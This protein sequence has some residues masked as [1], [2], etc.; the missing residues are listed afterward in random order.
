MWIS[1][2]SRKNGLIWNNWVFTVKM[3]LH[4]S[5]NYS[6]LFERVN[7][8]M[9]FYKYSLLLAS[10]RTS[11]VQ[12]LVFVAWCNCNE[13]ILGYNGYWSKCDTLQSCSLSV[14][15]WLRQ[16]T[17]IF[18]WTSVNDSKFLTF[19][20]YWGLTRHIFFIL[21]VVQI[22]LESKALSSHDKTEWNM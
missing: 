10:C 1:K 20:E 16:C 13:Q 9:F 18:I 22:R 6:A 11:P 15:I 5:L 21:L 19:H 8:E 12:K 14:I 7:I 17:L 3:E 4:S 2:F